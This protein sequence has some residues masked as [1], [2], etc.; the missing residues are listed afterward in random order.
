MLKD[1]CEP[2]TGVEDPADHAGEHHEEHGQQFEVATH[3][4]AGLH[5]AQTTSCKAPLHYH[6][7]I[8]RL[9]QLLRDKTSLQ[10]NKFETTESHLFSLYI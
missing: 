5:V 4:A 7:Q 8:E 1:W 9:D 3:D 10:S 2:Q 6:L